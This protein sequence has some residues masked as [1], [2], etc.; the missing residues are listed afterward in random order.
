M[1]LA[2]AWSAVA[3]ALAL[4]LHSMDI[5]QPAIVLGVILIG[6]VSSWVRTAPDDGRTG[7]DEHPSHRVVH[8]PVRGVHFPVA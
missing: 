3:T 6:F 5:P 8:V 7:A 1:R 2:I 4:L